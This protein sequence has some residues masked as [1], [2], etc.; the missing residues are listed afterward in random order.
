ME[1]SV[2]EWT[3]DDTY[4]QEVEESLPQGEGSASVRLRV[5]YLLEKVAEEKARI[6]EVEEF[7]A[8]RIEMI[9]THGDDEVAKL[10]RRVS[11]LESRIRLHL[12]FEGEA[13]KREFG[14]K[15]LDLPSGKVGYR[16]VAPT[17]TIEDAEKAIRWAEEKRI[18]VS[19]KEV[20]TLNKTPVLEWIAK[21]GELPPADCIDYVDGFDRFYIETRESK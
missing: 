13:F 7:T 20:K 17:V 16:A 21:T 5:D 3:V 4:E 12:P 15:S 11:F 6:R 2:K 19:R 9:R 18:E 10:Q 1:S 8:R 14:K